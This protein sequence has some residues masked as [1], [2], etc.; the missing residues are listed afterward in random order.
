MASVA[1][2]F[3]NQIKENDECRLFE[4]TDGYENGEQ[5]RDFVYVGDIVKLNLWLL[6]HPEVSGIFNAGTGKCQ[7]FNDVADA[8]IAFH[9][10]GKK[11]Y[12]PFPAHLKN[13]YQ[14]FTE[15]DLISLREAGYGEEFVDVATGVRLYLETL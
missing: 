15:A 6:D 8:V 13:A 12:I 4:G 2:H 7:S 10:K 1:Y 5:L 14:S 9:G 11:Q 3:N